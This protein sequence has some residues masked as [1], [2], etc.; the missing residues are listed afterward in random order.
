MS[1]IRLLHFVVVAS[2]HL[3]LCHTKAGICMS[4]NGDIFCSKSKVAIGMVKM[5]M[6]INDSF[7]R[8][9]GNRL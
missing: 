5:I 7:D 2:N 4:N 9:R 3:F 6:G 1:R 8:F